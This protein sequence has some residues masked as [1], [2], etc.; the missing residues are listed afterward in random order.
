MLFWR[1][2]NSKFQNLFFSSQWQKK[3]HKLNPIYFKLS[4]SE[5]SVINHLLSSI[6]CNEHLNLP[7]HSILLTGTTY[8]EISAYEKAKCFG[9]F[10]LCLSPCCMFFLNTENVEC[11]IGYAVWKSLC[12]QTLCPYSYFSEMW[13]WSLAWIVWS[14]GETWHLLLHW[15]DAQKTETF[16]PLP[17]KQAAVFG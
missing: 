4:A 6:F 12:L 5:E 15:T 1:T 13:I 14:Y 8:R 7:N 3:N 2:I 16:N 11:F 17:V 9:N 10:L